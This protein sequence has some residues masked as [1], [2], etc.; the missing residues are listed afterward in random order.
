[1]KLIKRILKETTC[2]G[3]T[4]DI[5]IKESSNSSV[6][7]WKRE[8]THQFSIVFHF[9]NVPNPDYGFSYYIDTIMDDYW[10]KNESGLCLYGHKYDYASVSGEV[11]GR[12]KK[13]ISEFVEAN[14]LKLHK[15]AK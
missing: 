3:K 13:F 14:Q 8:G 1:M 10:G 15:E 7:E 12:V 2:E 11:M 5:Y 4:L 6:D 9:N